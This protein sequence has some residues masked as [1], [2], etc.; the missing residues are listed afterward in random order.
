M[1]K[2][3]TVIL[4]VPIS[5]NAICQVPENFNFLNHARIGKQISTLNIFDSKLIASHSTGIDIISG[6]YE[7]I[8]KSH[9]QAEKT[10]LIV[11]NDST[12]Y[13]ASWDNRGSDFGINNLTAFA[14]KGGRIDRNESISNFQNIR[15]V[16]D[17]TFDST[18]GWWCSIEEEGILLQV[19]EGQILKE[20]SINTW[21]ADLFTSCNRDIYTIDGKRIMHFD[22]LK[23]NSR[24][25]LPEINDITFLDDYNFLLT[26]NKLLKYDCALENIIQ[27]WNFSFDTLSFAEIDIIETNVYVFTLFDDLYTVTKIDSASE[28]IEIYSDSIDENDSIQGFKMLSDSTHIIYGEHQFD[29][30]KHNFFKSINHN[31]LVTYPT[32]DVTLDQLLINILSDTIFES[33][34]PDS[35]TQAYEFKGSAIINN[36]DSET[37]YALNIFTTPYNSLF[38]ILGEFPFGRRISNE[39]P[40]NSNMDVSIWLQ[41]R[42]PKTNIDSMRISIPGANYRFLK[43]RYQTL[44]VDF[45]SSTVELDYQKIILEPNPAINYIQFDYLNKSTIHIINSYGQ[46]INKFESDSTMNRIDVSKYRPGSYYLIAIDNKGRRKIGK[47][48]KL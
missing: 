30:Y 36:N 12:L 4:I 45:T 11:P 39:I 41:E 18:G 14:S 43:N 42:A 37:V 47:F 2:I 16:H 7:L 44:P 48:I 1:K 34:Y 8:R 35:L 17:I 9:D 13:H 22:G 6:N 32:V 3:F 26:N 24:A 28:S 19:N 20:I 25:D 10:K 38:D 27:E 31:Y 40:S 46:T 33:G 15:D 23:C 29:L 21:E 5:T